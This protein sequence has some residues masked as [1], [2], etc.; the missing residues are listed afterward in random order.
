MIGW[1]SKKAARALRRTAETALAR[2]EENCPVRTGRLKGSLACTIEA[3]GER[4]AV[5]AN[6]DYA[7]YVELGAGKTPPNPFM[8]NALLEA[9]DEARKIYLEE[10]F[11]NG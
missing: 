5:S 4:A 2:A 3:P 11:G 1:N 10:M 7:V 6:T 9:A 8:Q